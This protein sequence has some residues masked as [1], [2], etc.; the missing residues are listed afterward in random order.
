MSDIIYQEK[1]SIGQY[2][3]ECIRWRSKSHQNNIHRHPELIAVREGNLLVGV[4]DREELISAGEYA[5][6]PGSTIHH[7]ASQG[8][9]VFDVCIFSEDYVPVFAKATKGKRALSAKFRC[10][11]TVARFADEKLFLTDRMPEFYSMTA[12][13]YAIAGEIIKQLTFVDVHPQYQ[14]LIDKIIQY[15]QTNYAENISLEKMAKQL[16]YESSYVSKVFHQVIH[17]HFS[18]YVNQFRVDAAAVLLR[19][20]N[21]SMAEIAMRSGFQSIRSFNHTFRD[22][23]GETPSA[24]LRRLRQSG[25]GSE[26]PPAP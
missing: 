20:T 9:T 22:I 11:E 23:T 24:M 8:D 4:D 5:Y 13:L 12:A 1:N 15:V 14:K 6:F 18:R 26:T 16:G 21:L 3:F 2:Y 10:E 17:M 19:E 7:Y 25:S